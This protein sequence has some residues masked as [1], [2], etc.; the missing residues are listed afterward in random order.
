[1]ADYLI[2][3]KPANKA[4]EFQLSS[5]TFLGIVQRVNDTIVSR[6]SYPLDSDLS[7]G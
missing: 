6:N 7:G 5:R 2:I 3:P 1:M 4:R